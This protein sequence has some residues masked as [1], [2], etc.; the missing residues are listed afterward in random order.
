MSTVPFSERGG[1]ARG[2]LDLVSG[3]YPAFVFGGSL[4]A[5]LPV[6]HFH[7]VT[8]TELEPKLRHLADNGYRSV[9][10]DEIA[11]YVRG[12]L[13]LP[14]RSVGLCFDDAW[15]S[16]ATVAAPLLQHYG[17]RA[18][19][20][21]IPARITEDGDGDSPFVTWRE[22][23]ALHTSGS[24][25]VQSHTDSHSRIFAS[26]EVEDFVQPGYDVT[27]LLNR[28]QL[29]PPPAL[30]FV[31]PA[32]LG[33]PLY[34]MRSRM[35]DGRRALVSPAVHEACVDFVAREGG[36]SFF[37]RPDWR[38]RLSALVLPGRETP[39]ERDDDHTRG[40]EEELARSRSAL[41]DRLK[42]SSVA[43]ICL[44]WGISGARTELLLKRTGYRS[45]F[46]NRLRGRHAVHAGDDPYWLKR[47]SNRYITR[48]PGR[49]R[50]YWFS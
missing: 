12:D 4:G 18:I 19:T 16:L 8:R 25:D 46:A 49:G 15:K 33:A 6:F 14:P 17:L 42:T 36:P 5:F 29:S 9:V 50:R 13:R 34:G 40:I 26:A 3:R 38:R 27:P 1:K 20:Y 24:I 22:L 28:P 39:F 47:L 48:L 11:S 7:D 30:A 37:S 35:S 32:A 10:S 45:A 21:A 44:P 43:H 23:A 31:T 2:G 41:N